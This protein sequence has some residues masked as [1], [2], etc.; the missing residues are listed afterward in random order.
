[1][2]C[3]RPSISMR[4]QPR[5]SDLENTNNQ[6]KLE[7]YK[8]NQAHLWQS[9]NRARCSKKCNQTPKLG[10]TP[11][12]TPHSLRPIWGWTEY[13]KGIVW[14]SLSKNINSRIQG[15]RSTIETGDQ[16]LQDQNIIIHNSAHNVYRCRTKSC[17]TNNQTLLSRNPTLP[18]SIDESNFVFLNADTLTSKM[19]KLHLHIIGINFSPKTTIAKYTHKNSY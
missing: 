15:E 12:T 14:R 18:K 9:Y 10:G 17:I 5:L 13:N 19:S 6:M 3:W 2:I 7:K 1:M 11:Q 4:N 8:T 16:M